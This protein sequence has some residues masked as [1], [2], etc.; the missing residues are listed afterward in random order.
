MAHVN[1]AYFESFSSCFL[2]IIVNMYLV[3][4]KKNYI[5]TYIFLFISTIQYKHFPF[6]H[7]GTVKKM[8][9]A[10][11][12]L[13]KL[14]MN[15]Y[16]NISNSFYFAFFINLCRIFCFDILFGSKKNDYIKQHRSHPIFLLFWLYIYIQYVCDGNRKI[17]SC[18][19]VVPE[20]F[21][22]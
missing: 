18:M 12:P 17:M 5:L 15:I 6:G 8:N 1:Y 10:V 20:N 16:S 7:V 3:Y 21:K 22:H 11:G 13:S 2:V 19:T 9:A 4:L 14:K